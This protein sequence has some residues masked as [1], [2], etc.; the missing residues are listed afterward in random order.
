M[1][2]TLPRGG[3]LL[4]EGSSPL[5]PHTPAQAAMDASEMRGM[6]L[7]PS[8]HIARLIADELRAME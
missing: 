3:L 6:P 5:P 8:R 2:G 7:L 4:T 1:Q